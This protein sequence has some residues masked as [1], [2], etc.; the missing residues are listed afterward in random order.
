[1]DPSAVD[2]RPLGWTIIKAGNQPPGTVVYGTMERVKSV[3]HRTLLPPW[4][5]GLTFAALLVAGCGTDTSSITASAED[6]ASAE[7][8][9]SADGASSPDGE[10]VVCA[11][12]EIPLGALDFLEPMSSRPEVQAAVGEFLESGEGAFWPQDGWQV[13]TISDTEVYV[14]ILQTEAQVRQDAEARQVDVMFDE[15]FGDGVDDTIMFSAHNVELADG[16]WRWAGSVSGEDCVLESTIPE[17]MNHVE[18]MLDP[19]APAPTP[20][21]VTVNLLATE[22]ECVSGQS[23]GDR[24]QAPT[25]VETEDAVLISMLAEPPDGDAFDCPGNPPQV[26]VVDLPSPLG[27]RQLLEGATT[28]GRISDYVGDAFG[29]AP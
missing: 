26:V 5:L 12:T 25:V 29:I 8:T 18:W 4:L 3:K 27:G 10:I 24:L 9:V 15:G 28:A 19:E 22:R 2:R 14:M 21:S 16:Q 13:A 11:G 17:G 6:A 23:M 7:D 1:M 20:D